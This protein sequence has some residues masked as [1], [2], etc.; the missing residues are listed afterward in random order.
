MV[1]YA[2]E[3][4]RNTWLTLAWLAGNGDRQFF[5]IKAD[6]KMLSSQRGLPTCSVS[7]DVR[8]LRKFRVLMQPV[9]PPAN[10]YHQG[11]NDNREY[12][13]AGG[14]NGEQDRGYRKEAETVAT[15]DSASTGRGRSSVA[16]TE[17]G[18]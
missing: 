13:R 1:N 7:D 3:V 4:A 2:E 15:K 17:G 10:W 12:Q 18:E 11:R 16:T 9:G 6:S 8:D 5:S 14:Y